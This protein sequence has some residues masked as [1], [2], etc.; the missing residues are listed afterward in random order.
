MRY[1]GNNWV[2]FRI[3]IGIRSSKESELIFSCRNH[4]LA[5]KWESSLS[6]ENGR[7]SDRN[8]VIPGGGIEMNKASTV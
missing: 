8:V 7:A 5:L 1:L 2:T 3:A 6:L 4:E